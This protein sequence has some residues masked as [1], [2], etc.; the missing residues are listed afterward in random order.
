MGCCVCGWNGERQRARERESRRWVRKLLANRFRDRKTKLQSD[1]RA[2]TGPAFERPSSWSHFNSFYYQHGCE[3]RQ[4]GSAVKAA[5]QHIRAS[6]KGDCHS[7]TSVL[8]GKNPLPN[9][10]SMSKYK[11]LENRYSSMSGL[12][13]TD[14]SLK[15]TL[16]E[17]IFSFFSFFFSTKAHYAHTNNSHTSHPTDGEGRPAAWFCVWHLE[18]TVAYGLGRAGAA[19][20]VWWPAFPLEKTPIHTIT[21]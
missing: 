14:E 8:G 1:V 16:H 21:F 5:L 7:K 18:G 17:S 15:W 9:I 3:S 6:H 11:R 20:A 10:I 2:C 12:W 19:C 13:L 4:S